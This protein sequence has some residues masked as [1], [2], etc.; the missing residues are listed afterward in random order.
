MHREPG[1]ARGT[2]TVASTFLWRRLDQPGHDSCR[3]LARRGGWRLT[4]AAVFLDAGQ[5]CHFHYEV[6]ASTGWRARR[7][8]VRGY[9][10]E[11]AVDV[12]IH[13][14]AAGA[15]RLDGH[16]VH[17]LAGCVDLDL[18]FTPATN[19][20][21][22]RRLALEVGQGAEAPAAYLRFPELDLVRLPQSYVRVSREEYAYRSPSTG[23]AGT[24][25][26]QDSG[27]VE[28]YPGLFEQIQ[29]RKRPGHG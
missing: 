23:Y 2:E 14:T 12:R 3:L 25:I 22:L 7:A 26:V 16:A 8:R 15:W 13:A 17:G 29:A 11:R 18:A 19:L 21:V 9:L 6:D 24:L 27:A 5:P 1:E 10:G 4:G 20:L 28:E